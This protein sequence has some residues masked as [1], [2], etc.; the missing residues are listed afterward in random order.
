MIIDGKNVVLGRLASFAAKEALKGNE[1]SIVNSEQII[2]TGNK[3]MIKKEFEE[4]RLR[5]GH[6]Q[7]GPKHPAI[8]EKM[9]KRAVRGMLPT[10]KQG[11]GKE[12][13]ERI[14]CYKG[15]P[16]KFEEKEI[17]K[18]DTPQKMKYSKIK[19]FGK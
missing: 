7:K 6:S 2:I 11:R 19:E 9:V 5:I 16:K 18:M 15:I 1:I 13:L 17:I 10:P 8:I 14:K 3:K 4:K 12:A